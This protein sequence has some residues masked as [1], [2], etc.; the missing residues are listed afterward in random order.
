MDIHFLSEIIGRVKPS[1]TL[2]ISEKAKSLKAQGIDIISLSAGEPDFDTPESIKQAA[3]LAIHQG[4]TKY[5]PVSGIPELK[6][7]ISNKF[8]Q[9][10]EL[11]Y[12]LDEIIVSPGGKAIIYNAF[13]A[14][15]N[16]G[17][18][19]L[20]PAPYWVSYPDMAL[21]AGAYPKRIQTQLK[22]EYKLTPEDLERNITEKSKWLILNS[23][24]NPTGSA[25][26][27][28]ELNALADLL[29]NYP[30]LHILSDD[31]YEKLI[32]DEY[33]FKTI[34]QIRP[35]LKPRTLTVNGVSKTY[36]MTGWR[37]GYAGGSKSLISAMSKVMSQS[38]SN[39]CSIAQWAALEALTGNQTFI[40]ERNQIFKHRRDLIINAFNQ[41]DGLNCATPKGA[42]Y[43][44]PDCSGLIGKKTPKGK[45]LHNDL[46][47]A[48]ALLE[49]INIAIVPG[50]AF[51]MSPAFR[52]SYASET[53]L[54]E[55]ACERIMQFTQD[56]TI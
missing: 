52:V 45:I 53:G 1:A 24:S 8:K 2:A 25:Y 33:E 18:E 16:P 19:I 40:K 32:Y 10:N 22:N 44:F 38:T 11:E 6:Q 15:L 54:I 51:G 20:I 27:E 4:K 35:E 55:Q 23:P 28:Q 47:I 9:D 5:T 14:T 3:I 26:N 41:I 13:I 34:A 30:N 29:V 31:I 46:D 21:L 43:V 17:D 39:A 36:A 50:S 56:L 49:E 37:I 7:A 48:Q 12:A 42:F